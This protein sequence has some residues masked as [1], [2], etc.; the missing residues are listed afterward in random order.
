MDNNLHVIFLGGSMLKK[1][2]LPMQETWVRSLGQEDP[3]EKEMATQSSSLAWEIPW[4][5]EPCG[6]QSMGSQKSQTWLND[7]TMKSADNLVP[8]SPAVFI[9][10]RLFGIRKSLD[11]LCFR[12]KIRGKGIVQGRWNNLH[13]S[14]CYRGKSFCDQRLPVTMDHFL[15]LWSLT[16][17]M[18]AATKIACN[19]LKIVA[20]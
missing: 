20:V 9:I 3:L 12:S 2:F 15:L 14:Y 10:S 5:E 1:F 17:S 19:L 11:A 16:V 18:R 4:T 6:L 7:W 8:G 13:L